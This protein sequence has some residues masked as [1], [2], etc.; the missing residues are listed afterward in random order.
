[1]LSHAELKE[2]A[3]SKP[4]VKSAYDELEDEYALARELIHARSAA[5]LTQEEVA[6]KMHTKAPAIARLESGRKH[7]PSIET[8]RKYA[9]AVGC[10]LEVR[11]VPANG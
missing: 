4:E 8:L 1:M 11:L 10:R 6:E 2:R 7:S 3:L 9:S 5:G